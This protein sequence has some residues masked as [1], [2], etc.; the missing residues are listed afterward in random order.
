MS[1]ASGV[2]LVMFCP[3]LRAPRALK[4][5]PPQNGFREGVVSSDTA[6]YKRS[7]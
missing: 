1:T 4:L 5:S 2:F 7:A 6:V 3:I